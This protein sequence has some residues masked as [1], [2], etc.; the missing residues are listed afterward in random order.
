[1]N[2]VKRHLNTEIAWGSVHFTTNDRL[3]ILQT[4]HILYSTSFHGSQI[5]DWQKSYSLS[6]RRRKFSL[7]L[8]SALFFEFPLA[9]KQ[10]I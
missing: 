6:E 5:L 1:M 8:R 9:C 10:T 4:L 7:Y 3:I 2:N